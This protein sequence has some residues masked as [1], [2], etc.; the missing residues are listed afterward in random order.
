MTLKITLFLFLIS[1]IF[2]STVW[3]PSTTEILADDINPV[4]YKLPDAD[5]STSSLRIFVEKRAAAAGINPELATCIVEHESQFRP[6]VD[7][8]DTGSTT[9]RGLWQINDYWHPDISD[10]FAHD[11]ELST[12]WSLEQIKNGNVGWWGTYWTY[13][14][15]IEVFL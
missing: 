5:H 14:S 1:A 4:E 8:P 11:A 9:S 6:Q 2:I 3:I 10:E 7:G 15:K 12:E 13:C